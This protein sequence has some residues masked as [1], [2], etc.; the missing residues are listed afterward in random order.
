M[1]S[2]VKLFVIVLAVLGVALG[3][4]AAWTYW[5]SNV[6][7][8]ARH[9]Q[10]VAQAETRWKT[11]PDA[12]REATLPLPKENDAVW[13][14][15][16]PK[17][18]T[19]VAIVAGTSGAALGR[20]VG[21]TPTTGLPGEV[22]NMV[23]SGHRYSN[24]APFADLLTLEKDDEVIVETSRGKYTYKVRVPAS[25]LTVNENASWVMQP[26]PGKDI[27]AHEAVLTLITQQ[28]LVPTS[29][30]SVAFAVLVDA[31]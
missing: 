15:E 1:R 31:P 6:V 17:T 2:P 11:L 8:E 5:L 14:L 3:G 24:G 9:D 23:L 21:W 13:V 30:R 29:D 26:V 10:A 4:V 19:R 28:D 27:D 20:G 7:A 22:G 16:I 12:G 25:E 18:S